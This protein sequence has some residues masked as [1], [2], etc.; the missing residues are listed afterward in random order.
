MK[1]IS[2]KTQRQITVGGDVHRQLIKDGYFK[3]NHVSKTRF[4]QVIYLPEDC[5][6]EILNYCDYN[7]VKNYT[8]THKININNDF[9]YRLFN[10]HKL[11]VLNIPSTLSGWHI[12]YQK[13]NYYKT[14]IEL[15][16][17]YCKQYNLDGLIVNHHFNGD[18]DDMF[19]TYY[20]KIN[21]IYR[22]GNLVHPR[23]HQ[24]D[25]KIYQPN[26]F[27]LF[28]IELFYDHP[29][30]KIR[31]NDKLQQMRKRDLTPLLDT[32]GY[33]TSGKHL[34]KYYIRNKF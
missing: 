12:L 22:V 9:W 2:P 1:I 32:N 3:A 29:K 8:L 4:Q 24:N 33:K 26:E 6:L 18:S 5:L 15:I 14:E 31:R 21:N 25:Y 30:T 27:I 23:Y 7:T 19:G 28:M 34:H 13:T 11:T 20:D 17:N 10:K 16:I